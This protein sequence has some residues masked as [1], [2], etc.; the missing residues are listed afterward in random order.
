MSKLRDAI[1]LRSYAQTDRLQAYTNEGF[2]RFD[3][4]NSNIANDVVRTILHV[5]FR[6]NPEV[7]QNLAKAPI[8]QTIPAA[9]KKVKFNPDAVS[10]ITPDEDGIDRSNP[11]AKIN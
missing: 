5:R 1:W 8:N 9:E 6:K 7:Q 2:A 4:R 3:D 10:N 11:T